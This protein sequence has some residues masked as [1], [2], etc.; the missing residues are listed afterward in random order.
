[1]SVPHSLPKRTN[2][3]VEERAATQDQLV[4]DAPT[5][6]PLT[7]EQIRQQYLADTKK[8]L[9][10]KWSSMVSV[11]QQLT[12]SLTGSMIQMTK[13]EDFPPLIQ[14]NASMNSDFVTGSNALLGIAFGL[15]EELLG[16][17]DE[18]MIN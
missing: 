16:E 15:A 8:Q 14:M 7:D 9:V 13:I 5:E 4:V 11:L 1:M 12:R 2:V 18:E 6:A 17:P 10:Q 3:Q